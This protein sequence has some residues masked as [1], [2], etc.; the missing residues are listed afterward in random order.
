MA[1][2]VNLKPCPFKDHGVDEIGITLQREYIS[3]EYFVFCEDCLCEGPHYMHKKDAV[4]AWN[5]RTK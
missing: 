2:K 4:N 1:E 5:R 3:K